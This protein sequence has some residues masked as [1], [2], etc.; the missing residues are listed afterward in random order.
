[1]SRRMTDIPDDNHTIA[2]MSDIRRQRLV[3]PRLNNKSGR[4]PQIDLP[5]SSRDFSEELQSNEERWMVILGT[6]K[7]ALSIG[8]VYLVGFGIVI[9]LMVWAWT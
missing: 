2:D 3:V 6:L 5:A 4:N 8:M 9:A 7:A 1:M